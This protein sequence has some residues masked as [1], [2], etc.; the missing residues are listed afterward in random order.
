MHNGYINIDNKKMSKSLGNFFT[1]REIAGKFPYAVIRFFVLSAHYRSPI[2]FADKLL[3]QAESGLN[4][5]LNCADNLEFLSEKSIGG[6][7]SDGDKAVLEGFRE[8]FVSAMDDDLNTAEAIGVIFE[9]VREVNTN[10]KKVN[11]KGYILYAKTLL[12][13]LTNVLGIEKTVKN[14]ETAVDTSEIEELIN[15]RTNAKKS[16]D[17]A[18]ADEIRAKLLDM[19]VI[20]EDTREGVKWRFKN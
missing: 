17:F 16:K 3:A 11:N 13:E 6:E 5:I 4:R 1:V 9:L 10:V 7:I 15:E 18:K 19:G 2:N 12:N 20:I 14:I 8:K